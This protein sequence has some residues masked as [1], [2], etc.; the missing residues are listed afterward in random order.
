MG[1]NSQEPLIGPK[2][3]TVALK[4]PYLGTSSKQMERDLK[5]DIRKCYN[6]VEA[7]MIFKS[8]SN[9]TPTVKD[10]IPYVNKS[11]VIYSGGF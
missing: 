11:M 2:L 7:R 6:S 3:H 8:P 10:H 9:F 1:C 5:R 4:L